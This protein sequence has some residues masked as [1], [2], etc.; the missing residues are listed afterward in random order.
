MDITLL[1]CGLFLIILSIPFYMGKLTDLIAG[2]NT[3]SPEEK[4][5]YDEKKL[6]RIFAMTLDILGILFLLGA[7]RILDFNSMF[8]L[9]IVISPTCIAL[10]NTITKKKK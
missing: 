6:C 1:I 9:C 2:Y 5:K 4:D 8:V 7:T 10:A 3:M